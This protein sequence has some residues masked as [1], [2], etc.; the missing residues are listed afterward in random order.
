MKYVDWNE[1]GELLTRLSEEV[2]SHTFDGVVAIG[3][4]GSMA[5]AYLASRLGRP[6]FIPVFVRHVRDG[7]GVRLVTHDECDVESLR[8]RLLVVDDSLIHGRAM[9]FVLDLLPKNTSAKT[10]VVYCRTGSEFKPDFV[11][12]YADESEEEILFPYDAP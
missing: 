2:R 6:A 4:G 7:N 1:Y 10:L 3:R 8:G 11:G 12:A 5:A 9:K